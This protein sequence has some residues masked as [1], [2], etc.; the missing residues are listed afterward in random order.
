MP[1]FDVFRNPRRGPYPLLVDLQSDLLAQLETRIVAPLAPRDRYPA[2]PPVR[3]APLATVD[4]IEH[5]IVVPLAAAVHRSIL[6][7]PVGSL[8]SRRAELIAAL[9]LLFTG[10]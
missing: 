1:Q 10:A 3:L 4:G 2:A 6:G 7:K 8:A 5:V 9:D